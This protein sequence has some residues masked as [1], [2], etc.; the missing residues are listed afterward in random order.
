MDLFIVCSFSCK[1]IDR[2]YFDYRTGNF[3]TRISLDFESNMGES[4]TRKDVGTDQYTVKESC[5]WMGE[6]NTVRLET[7]DLPYR[8]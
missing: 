6:I 7:F 1:S 5:Q 4:K 3:S 8:A 2:N